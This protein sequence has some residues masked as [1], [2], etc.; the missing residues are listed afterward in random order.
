[1]TIS[2]IGAF[3]PGGDLVGMMGVARNLREICRHKGLIWGVYVQPAWRKQ[4]LARAML[5]ELIERVK[6][7]PGVEKIMR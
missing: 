1:M 4:G 5:T 2:S 7:N 6:A 3:A